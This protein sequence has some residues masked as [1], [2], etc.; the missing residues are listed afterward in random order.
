MGFNIKLKFLS[1]FREFL[2]Y[3]HKSVEFRAKVF[4]AII[5]AKFDPDDNDFSLLLDIATEIYDD[6]R[7]RK[8]FLVQATK[9]YVAKVKR[10][11]HLTL[12]APLL[13]IDREIKMH[14]RYAKKI[15]FSHLRRLMN[16][17]E[18]ETLMQQQVYEFLLSEVKSYLALDKNH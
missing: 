12:D 3:H 14:R 2:V 4:A 17:D 15:D 7:E 10:N 5:A 9:E 18:D 11:D 13:S 1:A 8:N 6:D 16:G